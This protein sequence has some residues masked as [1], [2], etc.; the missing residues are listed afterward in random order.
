[1][2]GEKNAMSDLHIQEAGV[3]HQDQAGLFFEILQ[4]FNFVFEFSARHTENGKYSNE[5]TPEKIGFFGVFVLRPGEGHDFVVVHA[6]DADLHRG[7]S[8]Q[9]MICS[10][11]KGNA[12]TCQRKIM[13]RSSE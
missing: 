1:M 6:F 4:A 7:T 3:V 2:L 11:Y 9:F 8:F 13:E 10:Y 5:N 12:P